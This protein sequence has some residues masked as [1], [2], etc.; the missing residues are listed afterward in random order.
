MNISQL[1]RDFQTG[2]FFDLREVRTGEQAVP[3]HYAPVD[4]VY[5]VLE[6]AM[7]IV[8]NGGVCW[9]ESGSYVFIPAGRF[10]AHT[11]TADGCRYLL[12]S[13]PW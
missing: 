13:R 1:V 7:E 8:C 5:V 3:L 4:R 6:G 11:V 10:H 9:A 2:G 12:A